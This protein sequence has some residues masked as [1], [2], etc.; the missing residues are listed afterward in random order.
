MRISVFP[1][2]GHWGY[3][4]PRSVTL[5]LSQSLVVEHQLLQKLH[6]SLR[7]LTSNLRGRGTVSYRQEGAPEGTARIAPR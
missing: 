1:N 2:L 4:G 5:V 6:R 7:S 3:L